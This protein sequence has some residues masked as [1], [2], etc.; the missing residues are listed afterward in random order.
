MGSTPAATAGRKSH[1]LRNWLI[2]LG[3]F[4]ATAGGALY[5]I[6]ERLG[7]SL[8]TR[9][10]EILRARYQADVQLQAL[11]LSL[12]PR[13]HAVGEGLVLYM[14]GRTDLPPL[15]S[16]DKFTLNTDF[17]DVLTGPRRVDRL[18]LEGLKITVTRVAPT[19]N[20]PPV[21]K[22]GR[23]KKIPSFVIGEVVADGTTLTVVPLDPQKNPLV[24]ELRKLTLHSAGPN[25][26]MQY[27]TSMTNALPPGL[28]EAHGT[29]GPW[30]A[31]EPVDTPLTGEYTFRNA[32][33]A[34]FKGISGI[35]SSDGT[36]KGR[37]DHIET[38]GTTDVPDFRLNISGHP[39]D[40]KTEF[41]SI[42]DGGDGDTLLQ[43]V[44]AHFRNTTILAQGGVTGK[45]GIP[46]KTVKL[47]LVIS[48]GRMEDLLWLAL[49]ANKPFL[50]GRL[51]FRTKFLLPPGKR[52]VIEKLGLDGQFDVS[53]GHFT[54]VSVQDK[55]DG[56]SHRAKVTRANRSMKA[57]SF[58]I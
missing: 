48:D 13:I 33:L 50:T 8:R 36:F 1:K 23:P 11:Q 15:V 2:G 35:L 12:F 20:Q 34:V 16:I 9:I 27:K 28:I 55:L 3:V 7:P 25:Q 51:D 58:R 41:H 14:R 26:P 57:T 42:V 38:Q 18:V 46:G 32:D 24:F 4:L 56:L 29:F 21:D 52:D 5:Y 30:Q 49:K 17:S 31:A 44:K 37:L 6:S 53:Q 47:D 39:V 19:P 45:K 10:V 54:N 43:P 22:K 40:L